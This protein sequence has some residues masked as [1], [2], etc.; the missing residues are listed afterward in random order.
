MIVP[1]LKCSRTVAKPSS[2]VPAGHVLTA[3]IVLSAV[4]A[5]LFAAWIYLLRRLVLAGPGQAADA[6]TPP[7]GP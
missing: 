6:E 3:I 2:V 1:S 5:G 4:Y 7:H